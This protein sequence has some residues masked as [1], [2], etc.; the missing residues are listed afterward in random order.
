[1]S[2]CGSEETIVGK[3]KLVGSSGGITGGGRIP[4]PHMTVEFTNDGKVT[5]YEDGEPIWVSWYSTGVEK[6]IFSLDPLP[7]IQLSDGFVYAYSFPDSDTLVLSEDAYDGFTDT[8]R[9]I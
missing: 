3:W 9:R 7:V 8:Y 6:T 1:L 5:W 2:G 4:I